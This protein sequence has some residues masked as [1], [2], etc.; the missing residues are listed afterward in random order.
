MRGFPASR[1]GYE[2]C[3][4]GGHLHKRQIAILWLNI[5]PAA[6]VGNHVDGVAQIEG[7]KHGKLDAVVGGETQHR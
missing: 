3:A 4:R 1:Q 5:H 7:V 6:A 2:S